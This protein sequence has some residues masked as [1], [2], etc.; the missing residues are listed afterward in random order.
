MYRTAF[1]V[2][3]SML[4]AL[5]LYVFLVVSG[6]HFDAAQSV[7]FGEGVWFGC[8][9]RL[10]A[11]AY[12][13]GPRSTATLAFIGV[14]AVATA[15]TVGIIMKLL[16]YDRLPDAPHSILLSACVICFTIFAYWVAFYAGPDVLWY[17][18]GR[19]SPKTELPASR[20][21]RSHTFGYPATGESER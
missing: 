8:G 16:S 2:M 14:M 21:D 19:P 7:T 11:G 1:T 17:A 10:A 13:R 5:V 6:V 4:G 3:T 12:I 15:A 18:R 20:R 9:A